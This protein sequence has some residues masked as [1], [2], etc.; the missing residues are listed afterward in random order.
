[1]RKKVTIPFLILITLTLPN[2][3]FAHDPRIVGVFL[4][5]GLVGILIALLPL[6]LICFFIFQMLITKF[7][8]KN[9][10]L[11]ILIYW[12]VPILVASLPP[13]AACLLW[14]GAKCGLPPIFEWSLLWVGVLLALIL[15]IKVAIRRIRK[16]RKMANK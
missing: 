16:R 7:Y 10:F 11:K 13:I 2:T 5:A 1:M 4:L 6:Y 8:V 9:W 12:L 15:D 14:V 3:L